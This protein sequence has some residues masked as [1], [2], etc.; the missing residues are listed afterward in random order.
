MSILRNNSRERFT[1]VDNGI[2]EDERLSWEAKG[3]LVYLLSKPDGWVI[4]QAHIEN[5]G[6]AGR[7]KVRKLFSELYATGYL[8]SHQNRDSKGRVMGSEVVL[9]ECPSADN[10]NAGRPESR[11]TGKPVNSPLVNTELLV[12]TDTVVNTERRKGKKRSKPER[13]C[14]PDWQPKQSDLRKLLEEHPHLTG[15]DL[16][17]SLAMMRDHEFAK[18]RKDWDATFRNWIRRDGSRRNEAVRRNPSVDE[19]RRARLERIRNLES[20]AG[21]QS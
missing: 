4:N 10:R 2:L 14:P 5:L 13:R 9:V 16:Q 15:D 20:Q 1:V 3:L 17:R 12:S 19:Q 7:Y 21:R 8:I 6:T 11:F 18:P